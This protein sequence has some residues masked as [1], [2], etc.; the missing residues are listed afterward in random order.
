MNGD[1]LSFCGSCVFLSRVPWVDIEFLP[2][3]QCLRFIR[4]TCRF[5]HTYLPL[6][7]GIFNPCVTIS[8]GLE[9]SPGSAIRGAG[10]VTVV[11]LG[12]PSSNVRQPDSARERK[13]STRQTNQTG[14]AASKNSDPCLFGVGRWHCLGS[15]RRG[16]Q[17]H[18]LPC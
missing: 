13:L 16:E 6:A 15:R 1:P 18:V 8:S 7:V 10:G 14:L 4:C 12:G 5:D 9:R 17:G 2:R 3:G 11:C